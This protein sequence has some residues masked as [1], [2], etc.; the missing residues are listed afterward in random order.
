MFGDGA[1][2][3]GYLSHLRPFLGEIGVHLGADA[4]DALLNAPPATIPGLGLL[5]RGMRISK[6]GGNL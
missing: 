1:R 5:T 3:L 6:I 2:H 4:N